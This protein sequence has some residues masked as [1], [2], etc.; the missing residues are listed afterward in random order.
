MVLEHQQM[1]NEATFSDDEEQSQQSYRVLFPSYMHVIDTN[2]STNVSK[3]SKSKTNNSK[4]SLQ[5]E[6]N[7]N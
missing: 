2:I 7:M 6:G 5:S 1:T 3:K 4:E